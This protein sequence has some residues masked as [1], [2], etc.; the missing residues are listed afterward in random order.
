MENFKLNR[1]CTKDEFIC[2]NSYGHNI[3]TD[4]NLKHVACAEY[5]TMMCENDKFYVETYN[6]FG[7]V[8]KKYTLL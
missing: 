4:K 1:S 6:G 8:T 5:S 2:K 7:L 3:C